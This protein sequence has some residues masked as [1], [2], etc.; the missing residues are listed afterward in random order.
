MEN[1]SGAPSKYNNFEDEKSSNNFEDENS[2]SIYTR[3][4]TRTEITNIYKISRQLISI[5][6]KQKKYRT[7]ESG[8]YICVE[9]VINLINNSKKPIG[10]FK[11]EM[12][13]D[14]NGN[15]K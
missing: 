8:R 14:N 5:R 10:L 2:S 12:K 3:Y 15:D 13:G 1:K 11:S 7:D 9:D 4:L 6:V